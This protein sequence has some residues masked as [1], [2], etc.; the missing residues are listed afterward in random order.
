VEPQRDA[1]ALQILIDRVEPFHPETDMRNAEL[2][3]LML[4]PFGGASIG[5]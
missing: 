2:I 5:A 4:L 3:N 1:F